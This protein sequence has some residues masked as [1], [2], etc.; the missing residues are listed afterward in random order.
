[1]ME[2]NRK[3]DYDH[4]YFFMASFADEHVQYHAKFLKQ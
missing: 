4:S 3:Q 1:M 2:A